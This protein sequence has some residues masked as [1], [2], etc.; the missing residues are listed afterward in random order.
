MLVVEECRRLR[1]GGHRVDG[2]GLEER[3]LRGVADREQTSIQSRVTRPER[4]RQHAAHGAD[5]SVQRE[6]PHHEEARQAVGLDRTRR[7]QEPQ[8][9]GQVEADALFPKV[10][11]REVHGHAL[12]RKREAGVSDR[13]ADALP[14]LTHRRIREPDR[15]ERGQPLADIDLDADQGRVDAG[16]AGRDDPGQHHGPQAGEARPS[17]GA[18]PSSVRRTLV[19]TASA[20]PDLVASPDAQHGEEMSRPLLRARMPRHTAAYPSGHTTRVDRVG[21]E[22]EP[23]R[24]ADRS[25]RATPAASWSGATVGCRATSWC[26]RAGAPPSGSSQGSR[27]AGGGAPADAGAPRGAAGGG[28]RARPDPGAPRRQ[29]HARPCVAL[30]SMTRSGPGFDIGGDVAGARGCGLRPT[31]RPPRAVCRGP[32][33]SPAVAGPSAARSRRA[34]NP[35]RAGTAGTDEDLRR[36]AYVVVRRT[37]LGPWTVL[38]PT[39]TTVPRKARRRR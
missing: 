12:E 6:L 22:Q 19:S 24:G 39:E 8:R 30:D 27:R 4:H 11:R 2:E 10:R 35:A 26:A 15:G 25:P 17:C 36:S 7:G 33:R 34:H 38:R 1:E 32:D 23:R 28:R 18:S 9:D 14:T 31:G 5:R 37:A 21:E 16:E 3:G 13:G 29:V 20:A